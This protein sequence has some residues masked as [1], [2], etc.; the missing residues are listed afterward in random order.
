MSSSDRLYA[1]EHSGGRA[2]APHGLASPA[3]PTLWGAW[4][5][6]YNGCARSTGHTRPASLRFTGRSE[7]E[8]A[9]VTAV[10]ATRVPGAWGGFLRPAAGWFAALAK[11]KSPA[12]FPFS[13]LQVGPNL[14]RPWHLHLASA[15]QFELTILIYT[16]YHHTISTIYFHNSIRQKKRW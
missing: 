9:V 4:Y 7:C 8:C 3:L 10:G 12:H 13:S 14:G 2:L 5:V 11:F 6:W 1:D 16:V 15:A